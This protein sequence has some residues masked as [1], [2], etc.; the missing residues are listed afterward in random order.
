MTAHRQARAAGSILTLGGI[1]YRLDAVEGWGSSAIVYQASYPDSLNAQARHHV[2]IKELFPLGKGGIY[3][4]REGNIRCDPEEADRMELYR[5]RFFQG[6][7]ANLDLLSRAPQGAS[8]N[9]NSYEAYGTYYSVLAVHGGKNLKDLL[10][11]KGTFSLREAAVIL[12]KVLDALELFHQND[13]LHLDISPDNI[14]LLPQQALLIDYNSVWDT[15]CTDFSDF[16][17]SQKEGYTAPEVR[18]QN[19]A[20][21]G[22]ATDLYSCCAVFFHLLAGRRLK[23]EETVGSG[24]P[25]RLSAAL[26]KPL[27]EVSATAAAKTIQLLCRGLHT[28]SRKRYPSVRAMREDLEELVRRI[29]GKGITHSALWE[30]SRGAWMRRKGKESPYLD[31]MVRGPEG[32]MDRPALAAALSRG[33]C[34]LLTGPG[35]MGKSR[36]LEE[37]WRSGTA[38]YRPDRPVFW[39]LALKDYQESGG[40]SGFLRQ[41]ILNGLRF[42]PQQP[43][44]QDAL[45]QLEELFDRVGPGGQVSVVVLL[46]GLNEAGPRQE[47]LLQE[48]EGLSKRPGVGVV[49]THRSDGVRDYGLSG[50]R[51]L[52]LLPLR[53]EQVDRQL[54]DAGQTAP[55]DEALRTLLTN[56][57]MLFLYL[58]AQSA[59][60]DQPESKPPTS[61]EELVARY[62]EQ[63]GQRAARADAGS[64]EKQLCSRYI[65]HHLLPDIAAE[66]AR[67]KKTLLTFGRLCAIADKSY[68]NLRSASFGAAFPAYRG[69]S[70]LMLAGIHGPAEW[71]DL[72]VR[73]QLID[74]FALLT[75]T[76]GGHY[77]LRHDNFQAVLAREAGDNRRRFRL[78]LWRAWRVRGAAILAAAALTVGGGAALAGRLVPGALTGQVSYNQEEA[79]LIYD[80]LT[81]LNGN[82][83]K[84][85]SQVSA[86]QAILEQAAISDVLDNQD[87]RARADLAGFIDHKRQQL[88]A[89]YAAPLDDGLRQALEPLE[90]KKD[91]FSIA[92]L[93]RLCRCPTEMETVSDAALDWL[94]Q[95][96]CEPDSIY[97]SRDK[98]ERLVYAYQTYLEAE[99]RY[100][101]YL[102]AE[103]LAQMTQEQQE[104]VTQTLTYLEAF[105]DFYDG[106]GSVDP[107]RLPDGAKQAYE[108]LKTA[109]LE[110]ASQGYPIQWP[111]E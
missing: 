84:W 76:A 82:L 88:D 61:M 27:K 102:L 8:G 95:S 39:Y 99:V 87:S 91:L 44:Y 9:L 101:S 89:F 54:E 100:V 80:A 85:S 14:L 13:L 75:E 98:R 46:D 29:D 106:P 77:G 56:P 57:M 107:A 65:L 5:Q 53:R 96:L 41:S 110:M 16:S 79:A 104:Q 97:D 35:G 47:P 105:G 62:L 32:D 15:R 86:Q 4:D 94:R 73:E 30:S 25:Q 69:K 1:P 33:D 19:T 58:E 108:T 59:G 10:D 71:Y 2:F 64:Q 12:E 83:G 3:R 72:A 70:R 42:S 92:D 49:V 26:A 66:M 81:C 21:I 67:Q 24:M 28:L 17:F 34:C 111:E 90:E 51:P 31:Q 23:E 109:R 78:G 7:Q 74:R 60:P 6:N 43:T 40:A 68:R 45:H 55:E 103:L 37:L 50:F 20:E 93:E 52:T 38:V 22:Y 48:I 63:L 18:L 11:H 36:L